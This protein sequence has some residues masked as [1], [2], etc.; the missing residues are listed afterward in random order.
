MGWDTEEGRGGGGS[1]V[2]QTPMY[3]MEK[4]AKGYVPSFSSHAEAAPISPLSP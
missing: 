1:P 2:E 3:G 4:G